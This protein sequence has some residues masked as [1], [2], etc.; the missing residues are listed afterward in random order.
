MIDM[1][2][3]GIFIDVP[4]S[5]VAGTKLELSM[6]WTGLYHGRQTMRLFLIASVTRVER[7]GT[8]LRI[9]SHRFRD[10]TSQRVRLQRSEK[11][12]AVA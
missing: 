10:V 4:D 5:L 9:L 1:S 12:L 8:A 6:E 3:T 11:K 7:R 2:A